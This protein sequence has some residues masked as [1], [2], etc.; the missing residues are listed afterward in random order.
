MSRFQRLLELS[1]TCPETKKLVTLLRR[2]R[3]VELETVNICNALCSF[4]LYKNNVPKRQEMPK[5]VF[6]NVIDQIAVLGTD[7]LCLVPMLGDPLLD[8]YLMG[9]VDKLAEAANFREIR[10]VTNALAFDRWADDDIVKLLNVVGVFQISIGPNLRVY[11][12]LFGVDRFELLISQLERLTDLWDRI[13]NKPRKVEFCGR[14]CGDSFEVDQRLEQISEMLCTVK[15]IVWRTEYLDWGGEI[16][17]LP[18]GTRVVK[19]DDTS[20]RTAPCAFALAPHVFQDGK[21]GLCAC[22]GASDTLQI[23]S[24]KNN[25]WQEILT[26]NYRLSMIFSFIE[27]KHPGYCKKCSFYRRERTLVWEELKEKIEESYA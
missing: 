5:D 10:F 15:P 13:E 21:V 16:T 20:Q 6:A 3:V 14:A 12:E 23:G 4:C 27:N 9:R 25:N 1:A 26:S 8:R 11:K 19:V 17:D 7:E 24:F 22:A 2:P 18:L